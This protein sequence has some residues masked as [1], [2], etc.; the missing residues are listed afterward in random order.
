MDTF[1]AAS[2]IPILYRDKRVLVAVKPSGI[3]STNEPGGMPEL[4]RQS[5]H[6]P[7]ACIRNVHRLDAV[8]GGIMVFACSRVADS[9]LSEQ[10]RT[11]KFQKRYLAVVYGCPNEPTGELRDWLYYDPHNRM[12]F[13]VSGPGK[14]I[15]EASLEY[16]LLGRC[17][18][19]S[20]VGIQLNTGRT[21]QIRVQFASRGWP[22]VGDRKYGSCISSAYET[23]IALHSAFISFMH[24]ETEEA[25]FF[26]DPPP[27]R[28]PW[29]EFHDSLFSAVRDWR[30]NP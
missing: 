30:V 15:K 8:V 1:H 27:K 6:E 20:L 11:G 3:L 29:T 2:E 25:M 12:T 13:P 16:R 23:P 5:L 21:H 14:D 28:F 18:N 10:I 17:C 22:I 9:L 7:N 24:P 26:F 19:F 4:L